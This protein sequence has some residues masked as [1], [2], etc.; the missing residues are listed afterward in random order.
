MLDM[1]GI[2]IY[3]KPGYSENVE[4]LQMLRSWANSGAETRNR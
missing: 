4:K 1:S 2:P 3:L